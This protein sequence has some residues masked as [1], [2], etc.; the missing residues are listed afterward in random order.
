MI[1]INF[2]KSIYTV[3]FA[4]IYVCAVSQTKNV[5]VIKITSQKFANITEIKE[6][7]TSIPKDYEIQSTEYVFN[8]GDPLPISMNGNE[9]PVSVTNTELINKKGTVIHVSIMIFKETKVMNKKC[10]IIIE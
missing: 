8:D 7:V 5:E 4:F 3:A 10:K 9:V 1:K 2:I 6:L